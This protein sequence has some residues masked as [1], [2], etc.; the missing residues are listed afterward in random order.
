MYGFTL[1]MKNYVDMNIFLVRNTKLGQNDSIWDSGRA[2]QK[3][4]L[5]WQN[6]DSWNVC[7][8]K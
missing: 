7:K 2:Y 1:L 8:N 4:G 6:R 5:F 3:P